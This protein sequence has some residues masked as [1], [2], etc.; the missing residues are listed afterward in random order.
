MSTPS[1]VGDELRERVEPRLDLAPVEQFVLEALVM[2]GGG[3]RGAALVVPVP[4]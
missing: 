1:I 2:D 3:R 4:A